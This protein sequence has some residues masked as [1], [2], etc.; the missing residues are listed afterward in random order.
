MDALVRL[1][2]DR[3]ETATVQF[4][5]AVAT[6]ALLLA[7][8]AW[9]TILRKPIAAAWLKHAERALTGALVLVALCSCL[10]YF[11]G[12]RN[13]PNKDE[14]GWL[15]RWDIY[16]Q[17]FGAKYLP[18]LGYFRTYECTWELDAEHERHFSKVKQM[19][20]IRTLRVGP[21]RE[22]AG[23]RDCAELFTPER[24][25]EFLADID[26]MWDLG[27]HW[28]WPKL[29]GDKGFNGPPFHAFVVGKLV[30]ISGLD[31]A[32][33][34][35]VAAIDVILMLAA[36]A[37]IAWVWDLRTAA[38]AA[39]FFAAN[40]PNR[41]NYMGGS[42]LRFDY[43]AMLIFALAAM[44]RDRFG[45]AGVC[46]AWATMSRAFPAIF[47]VGLGVKAASELLITRKLPRE[48]LRFFVG[49]G[50]A[51]AVMFGLSLTLDHGLHNWVEWWNNIETHT[52]HTRGFRVGFKH[53]FM[54]D[55]SLAADQG[56]VGWAKKTAHYQ[57]RAPWFYLS[58]LILLAPLLI[59]VR[60]LDAVTFTALFATAGFLLL[61]IATRYYYAMMVLPILIDRD[62][63]RDRKHMIQ[64]ALLLLTA[65]VL[66]KI[67]EVNPH[68]AFHYNTACT[69]V[70]TGYWMLVGAMLWMDPWLRDRTTLPGSSVA[71]GGQVT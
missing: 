12:Q 24:K 1:L 31:R 55:G 65:A 38:I 60:K 8:V 15:H 19:R 22:I 57:P 5:L 50:V 48:Y 10:Q 26:A 53:M 47:V 46:V 27:L 20:D 71:V 44:K 70:F 49:F 30:T 21:V 32:G 66:T 67:A 25:A 35:W 64:V 17:V 54:L 28:M 58:I 13:D 41:F 11:Y 68:I 52:A 23:E 37:V 34:T 40:F 7:A 39:I 51:G 63:F 33:L 45:L 18:E 56:F 29:F 61:T 62:M 6:I 16:H 4:T 43:I 14:H 2:T 69:A 59:A 3:H 36:F 9:R 42:I